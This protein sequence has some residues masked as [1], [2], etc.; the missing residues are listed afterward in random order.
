MRGRNRV[1][2]SL[3]ETQH[4]CL[5]SCAGAGN[6]EQLAGGSGGCCRDCQQPLL[7]AHNMFTKFVKM[8]NS[9]K[10]WCR[11]KA[12]EPSSRRCAAHLG[13]PSEGNPSCNSSK[14]MAG[15]FWGDCPW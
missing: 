9:E 5:W 12:L 2:P 6:N 3:P 13:R 8:R 4:C 10:G 15:R 14:H 11:P 7:S 1:W